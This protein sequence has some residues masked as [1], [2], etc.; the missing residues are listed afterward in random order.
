MEQI[1]KLK[2][3]KTKERFSYIWD[4]YKWVI[5]LGVVALIVVLNIVRAFGSR[6]E[7]ALYVL[8]VNADANAVGGKPE[9]LFTDFLT[10]HGFDPDKEE[11]LV[12]TGIT[13]LEGT[14]ANEVYAMQAIVTILGSGAADVCLMDEDLF[15]QEAS[16]G[17]FVPVQFYLTEEEMDRYADR[18]VWVE[19]DPDIEPIAEAGEDSAKGTLYARG[20]R[21][22]EGMIRES[23]LY[24]NIDPIV[25]IAYASEKKELASELVHEL[26]K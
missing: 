6:K 4:Y 13:Y 21:L 12:N 9:E 3:M 19:A 7:T 22:T 15:V 14:A 11:V 5:I 18:I 24:G 25:G 20:I 1:P 23:G 2:D 16:L 8:A 26:L 10:E 17:A